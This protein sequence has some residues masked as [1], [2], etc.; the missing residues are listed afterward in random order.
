[1]IRLART[2][3]PHAKNFIYEQARA[4]IDYYAPV[5]VE[6][7][8]N[9]VKV[10]GSKCTYFQKILH[11]Y[12]CTCMTEVN[13]IVS[14]NKNIVTLKEKDVEIDYS[15][16][17]FGSVEDNIDTEHQILLDSSLNSEIDSNGTDLF[18]TSI[19]GNSVDC[20]ICYR[21]G[22]VPC[23]QPVTCCR[24]VF[25][26]HNMVGSTGYEIID[27]LP[28][29]FYR[30][31]SN[32]TVTFCT[33]VPQYFTEVAYRFYDNKEPLDTCLE[34]TR[35]ALFSH[36]GKTFNLVVNCERF[37]HLVLQYRISDYTEID[38]PQDQKS[39]DLSA[40]LDT[41]G[42]V[43]MVT[44]RAVP[45]IISGDIVYNHDINRMF[46]VTN[47]SYYRLRNGWPLGWNVTGRL[48]QKD[49]ALFHLNDLIVLE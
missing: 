24:Q 22:Y 16:P 47:F 20:G 37:T 7:Y 9:S 18:T 42:D 21:T 15:V 8:A 13:G 35:Y 3:S 31:I 48:V 12:S 17:L 41:I 25:A 38:F 2:F 34:T 39:L 11:G 26:T 4:R 6:Q 19:F 27:T 23:Y 32:G 43:Q 14:P 44:T 1:M 36:R 46:K 49:E 29:T 10:N 45:R 5:A 30:D 28:K 33:T 40:F